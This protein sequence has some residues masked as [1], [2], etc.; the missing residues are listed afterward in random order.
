MNVLLNAVSLFLVAKDVE[1]SQGLDFLQ[2]EILDDS[3]R[4]KVLSFAEQPT[5]CDLNR[6]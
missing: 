6:I 3:R 5:F 4:H 2:Y 1:L